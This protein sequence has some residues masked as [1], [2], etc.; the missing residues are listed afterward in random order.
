MDIDTIT[1]IKSF[2][3]NRKIVNTFFNP[4]FFTLLAKKS[5]KIFPK[6]KGYLFV[7]ELFA[8]NDIFVALRNKKLLL[9]LY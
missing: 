3:I 5:P 1:S 9:P 4:V 7:S 8:L 6:H 2:I